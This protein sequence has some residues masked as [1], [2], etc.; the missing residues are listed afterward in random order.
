VF[1]EVLTEHLG[2]TQMASVFPN[3]KTKPVEVL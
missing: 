3:Y 2:V 1:A